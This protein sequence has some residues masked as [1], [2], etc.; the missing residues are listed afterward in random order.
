M[1]TNRIV[2]A[3]AAGDLG[4]RIVRALVARG[5]DVQALLRVGSD[6]A[7]VERVQHAGAAAVVVDFADRASLARAC[8]G[9]GCVVSALSG[10]GDVIVETQGRLLDAA[11]EA[12]VPRFIPSDFSLDYTGLPEGSNRNFDLRRRFRERIDGAPIRATS[13]FNGAFADML[14]GQMPLIVRPLRR[15]LYWG[16]ADQRFSLTT[17]DDTAAYTAE[18]AF[19]PST[20]R[21]LHIAGTEASVRDLARLMTDVSGHRYRPMRAGSLKG[22]SMMIGVVRR[23]FPQPQAVFPAW[24]GMQYLHNMFSGGAPSGPIDNGRYPDLRWTDLREVLSR[25]SG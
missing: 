15:V 1:T 12:G 5:A 22:L 18:A 7:K 4:D 9:A 20:P 24:Q 10:L 14:A 19:D 11:I 16:S 21:D 23:I 13:I 17:K 3:G 25:G 6:P 2:V 8:G